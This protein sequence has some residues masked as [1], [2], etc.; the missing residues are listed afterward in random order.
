MSFEQAPLR[1]V[2]AQYGVRKVGG[3]QGLIKTE[4]FGNEASI[5]F[6]G[7]ALD[8]KVEIPAG[9]IVT[10]IIDLLATGAVATATVGAVDISLATGAE[11]TYVEVPLGG[12]LTVT[13]PTA[14]S[15]VVKYYNK[16]G[17]A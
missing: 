14:G 9:A 2:N 6:D 4:G 15:V 17:I 7:D 16:A 8:N 11:G 5:N 10:Q 3:S 13:G 1:G 12:T